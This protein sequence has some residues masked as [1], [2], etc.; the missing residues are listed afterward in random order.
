MKPKTTTR[1]VYEA[2]MQII[3][4]K[5]ARGTLNPVATDA[6]I[7]DTL[8]MPRMQVAFE[9]GRISMYDVA[10]IGETINGFYIAKKD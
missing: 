2:G 6:E 8:H 9:F 3:A 4:D 7:A 10:R 1:L 5:D